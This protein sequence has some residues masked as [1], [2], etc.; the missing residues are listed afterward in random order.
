MQNGNILGVVRSPFDARCASV[1]AA[2]E[3]VGE[4]VDK[5]TF[6]PPPLSLLPRGEERSF[7]RKLLAIHFQ[8]VKVLRKMKSAKCKM[9]NAR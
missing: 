7:L 8:R 6:G 1:C 3:R 5:R 2:R 4:R 9:Q